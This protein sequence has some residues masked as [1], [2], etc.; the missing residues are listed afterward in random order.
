MISRQDTQ[1]SSSG[2]V[3]STGR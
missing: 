3:W 2:Q 1:C